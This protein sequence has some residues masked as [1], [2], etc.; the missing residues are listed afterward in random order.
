LFI[1]RYAMTPKTL[2]RIP[3]RAATMVEYGIMLALVLLIAYMAFQELGNKTGQAA[4]D[5]A[6]AFQQ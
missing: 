5:T 3:Q 6:A 4:V 1:K 2:R